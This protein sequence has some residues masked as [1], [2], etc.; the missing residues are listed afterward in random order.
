M[1]LWRTASF[2]RQSKMYVT[3]L[4]EA[5]KL[6]AKVN[7]IGILLMA[8]VSSNGTSMVNF[9]GMPKSS[10]VGLPWWPHNLSV[11]AVKNTH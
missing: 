2:S 10:A 9:S 3:A 1:N 8:S 4:Q 7:D 6:A 5:Y 11:V